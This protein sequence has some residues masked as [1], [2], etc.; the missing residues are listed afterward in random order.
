MLREEEAS[1][2]LGRRF[3][4]IEQLPKE[5]KAVLPKE[6]Q[7]IF[8]ETF[9][10]A[11]DKGLKRHGCFRYAWTMVRNEGY[12]RHWRT[13]RWFRLRVKLFAQ[14]KSEGRGD[15]TNRLEVSS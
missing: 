6:A 4:R 12:R 11:C 3:T 13:G 8:V 9:N 2:G 7:E 10:I 5:V 1:E 14:K 15:K